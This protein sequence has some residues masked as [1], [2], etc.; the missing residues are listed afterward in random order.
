[1]K[2]GSRRNNHN[3]PN[4]TS[5]YHGVIA[6]C[7]KCKS[8]FQPDCKTSPIKRLQHHLDHVP[9]LEAQLRAVL[10]V[11]VVERLAVLYVIL[12]GSVLR[13]LLEADL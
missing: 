9:G 2:L 3:G 10:P 8:R 13:G 1:M 7:L 6:Q 4:F 12:F 11:K 5:T